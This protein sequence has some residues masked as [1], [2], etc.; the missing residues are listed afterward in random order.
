MSLQIKKVFGGRIEKKIR[1]L[2]ATPEYVAVGG[3]NT[4]VQVYDREGE[5]MMVSY[6]LLPRICRKKVWAL[7]SGVVY[8]KKPCFNWCPTTV[9]EYSA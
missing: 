9:I 2:V 7:F 1:V 8:K 4:K 5:K 6:T 3:D